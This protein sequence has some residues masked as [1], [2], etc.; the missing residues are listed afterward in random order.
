MND[1][2]WKTFFH[3]V[4]LEF[5]HHV[6]PLEQTAVEA[7][8]IQQ[9]LRLLPGAAVLDVPCGQGR[10]A[11]ALAGRG[12]H[13]IGVDLCAEELDAARQLARDRNVAVQWEHRDMRDLPWENTF[14]GAYCFGNSFGY[15]DDAA[16]AAF[17][18]AVQRSLKPGGRFLLDYP[19]LAESFL[20]KFQERLWFQA[21]DLILLVQHRFDPRTSRTETEYTFIKDGKVEN[22]PGSHRVYPFKELHD[23]LGRVGFTD[24]QGYG[25]LHKE[26]LKLGSPHPYILCRKA[27][28]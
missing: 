9:Q 26:A 23:L 3:G 4:A 5:W 6:I 27:G 17:L 21:D 19:L 8:F 20:P 1:D 24:I 28:A 2:W 10:L 7:E 13:V 25:S 15:M 22:R 12:H 18:A 14:D 11:L 16:N